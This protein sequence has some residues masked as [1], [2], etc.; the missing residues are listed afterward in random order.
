[1]DN[2]H[3]PAGGDEHASRPTEQFW[4]GPGPAG[5]PGGDAGQGDPGHG[6]PGDGAAAHG[7]PGYGAPG[8]GG[9]YGQQWPGGGPGPGQPGPDPRQFPSPRGRRRSL[10]WGAGLAMVALLAGG[11]AIAGVALAGNSSPARPAGSSADALPGPAPAGPA[12]QAAVLNAAL[13]S[14]G[15][16]TAP[17][18]L[19]SSGAVAGLAS[20]AAA[21]SGPGSAGADATGPV[22]RCL[23]ARAAARAAGRP[24]LARRIRA[25]CLRPLL[26][27]LA[28]RGVHGEFTFRAKDGYKTLAFERGTIQSAS[29]QDIVV[30]APDGTTWT[31]NLVP[32]TVVREN[33]SKVGTS[34]LA[35]GEQVW[36]GGPVVQGARDSRLIVIRPPKGSASPSPAAG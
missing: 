34:A 17:A 35:A 3:L 2:T 16:P 10:S 18:Y 33:G 32:S 7:G 30:Q 5:H 23:R 31:W 12:G 14:A 27:R 21:A 1:M 20:A 25:A 11:G 26:R 22:A 13:S 24:A 4:H 15:A 8:Y 29:G 6:G 36:T 28:L 9:P 19:D